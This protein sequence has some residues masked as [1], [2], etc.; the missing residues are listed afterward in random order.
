MGNRDLEFLVIGL[1]VIVLSTTLHEFGHAISADRLGDP[2]PRQDGRITLWPDK[3]FDIFGFIMMCVTVF[4]GFGI[5]W[6]KPA[7][8]NPEK[9]PDTVCSPPGTEMNRR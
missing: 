5:G 4:T 6:G 8:M 7:P 2:T 3:H 1:I 9:N